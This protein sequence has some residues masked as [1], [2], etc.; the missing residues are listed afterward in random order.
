MHNLLP[1]WAFNGSYKRSAYGSVDVNINV[2]ERLEE[3]HESTSDF[4]FIIRKAVFI[5]QAARDRL[6]NIL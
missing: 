5:A 4:L 1:V 3:I 2:Q 6:R